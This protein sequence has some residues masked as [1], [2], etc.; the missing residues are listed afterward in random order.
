[1]PPS[2][3]K[4]KK[5]SKAHAT[6]A[7]KTPQKSNVASIEEPQ[8]EP[9]QARKE[10]LK[11]VYPAPKER[12]VMYPRL[13]RRSASGSDVVQGELVVLH[14]LTLQKKRVLLFG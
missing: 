14:Q 1:M 10:E 8:P 6:S 9:V 4:R 2:K 13:K 7:K 3:K 11:P 12:I 5:K